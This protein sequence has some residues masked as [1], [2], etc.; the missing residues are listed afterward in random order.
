MLSV[1]RSWSS[2]RPCGSAY[3]QSAPQTQ[4][5]R[6]D[7]RT[8]TLV[9]W[10]KKS[11]K[12]APERVQMTGK[13]K[14]KEVPFMSVYM[15][16]CFS[17]MGDRLSQLGMCEGMVF[18]SVSLWPAVC[19]SRSPIMLS[20][21]RR[22]FN[23]SLS[24]MFKAWKGVL[25]IRKSYIETYNIQTAIQTK[26]YRKDST[27]PVSTLRMAKY[28]RET[29]VQYNSTTDCGFKKNHEA[30]PTTLWIQ[31]KQIIIM[32]TKIW[33]IARLLYLTEFNNTLECYLVEGVVCVVDCSSHNITHHNWHQDVGASL[34]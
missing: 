8:L 10:E 23:V 26:Q 13:R 29:P 24:R 19:I 5:D 6:S 4:S 32:F 12:Q 1:C 18:C 22:A 21:W 2:R 7:S 27:P 30:E 11:R 28:C 16:L 33:F 9:S 14:G 3:T 34:N 15:Y 20:S 25:A 17:V 31:E